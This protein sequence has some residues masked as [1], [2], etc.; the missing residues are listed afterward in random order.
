MSF[1]PGGR[2]S[3]VTAD[4]NMEDAYF[5]EEGMGAYQHGDDVIAFGPGIAKHTWA[6]MRGM[7]PKQ[8]GHSVYI[9]G[10]T[11]FRHVIEIG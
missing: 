9:T 8:K 6:Q 10:Y 2:L 11:P 3:G 7:L 5:L 4:K 1:R